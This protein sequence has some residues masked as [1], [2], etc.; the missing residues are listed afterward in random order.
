MGTCALPVLGLAYRSVIA[1][2]TAASVPVQKE[3][4]SNQGAYGGEDPPVARKP[5]PRTGFTCIRIN[6]AGRGPIIIKLGIRCRSFLC[7][8]LGSEYGLPGKSH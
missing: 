6:I 5:I 3:A 4:C 8:D 7:L 2:N 1:R